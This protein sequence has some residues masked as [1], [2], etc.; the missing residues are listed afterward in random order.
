MDQIL[1]G[2]EFTF[3]YLDDII[4]G[5]ISPADHQ[6]RLRQVLT[7]LQKH[8]VILNRD[9]C[10]VGLDKIEYLGH[11]ISGAGIQPTQQKVEA[12]HRA[13]TPR[14][15]KTLRAFLGLINYYG[16]FMANL[17]S[18]LSPLYELLKLDSKW[19]WGTIQ[20][21]AFQRAK[22]Q[23][24]GDTIL[25][26]YSPDL[27]LVLSSDASS[28][29]LGA[30][31]AHRMPGG[32]ERP[33]AFASR[34]LNAAEC[35]YSQVE[36][37]ALAIMFGLKRFHH[38]IFG[39]KFLIKTDHRPLLTLFGPRHEVSAHTL[40]RINR[41][42]M[43]LAEYSYEI[44]FVTTNK[45]SADYCSRAPVDPAPP[46]A[47]VDKTIN[48]I[49]HNAIEEIPLTHTQIERA[50][51]NDATLMEVSRLLTCGWPEKMNSDNPEVSKFAR[52]S[53]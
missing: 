13:E 52:V 46:T 36:K 47:E 32:G 25:V 37:E 50:T 10:E 40:S 1:E 2:Q 21:G 12:I 14:D 30:I 7:R 19:H 41:W 27:P 16:K 34:K 18:L 17:S 33:I 22:D 29:G 48:A 53:Q 38:Y 23:L 8:Q 49:L 51:R 20:Q 24:S 42:A 45:M 9:K 44:E 35:N 26:H 39:R 31:L 4:V 43:T 3:G 11:L 15:V 28:F 6:Q 5:G